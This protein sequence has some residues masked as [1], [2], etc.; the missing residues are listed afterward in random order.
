MSYFGRNFLKPRMRLLDVGGNISSKHFLDFN[1]DL[2]ILDLKQ[3]NHPEIR[4]IQAEFC[5]WQPDAVFDAIWCSHTLEHVKNV[6]EFIRKMLEVTTDDAV[7][8]VVVPPYKDL[9]V[10]GH[11]NLFTPG[12]LCYNLVLA[13]QNLQNAVVIKHLNNIA[14]FWNRFDW[15]LPPLKYD[16]GDLEM[17]D[18]MFPKHVYQDINGVRNWERIRASDFDDL[19]DAGS[20]CGTCPRS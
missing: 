17:L 4:S 12:T 11:I 7:L 9:L 2:T 3:V 1:I 14:V 20:V 8:A 5:S 15:P 19:L 6:G 18:S 16:K 13:K 10:G